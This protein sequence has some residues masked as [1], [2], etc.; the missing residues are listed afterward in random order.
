[1]QIILKYGG[2]IG[3]LAS[4]VHA[5]LY[6]VTMTGQVSSVSD[7]RTSGDDVFDGTAWDVDTYSPSVGDE[8]SYEVIY[9]TDIDPSAFNDQGDSQ[10]AIYDAH[11]ASSISLNGNAISGF[12]SITNFI[13][14]D[15]E[16]FGGLQL[17]GGHFDVYAFFTRQDGL[18]DL[19]N[20]G[21]LPTS[22]AF[23]NGLNL[24][25]LLITN[26]DNFEI[27][28]DTGDPFSVSVEQIPVP[29]TLALAGIGGLMSVRRRR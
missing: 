22:E 15:V 9:D 18:G 27:W 20:G 28:A 21:M 19:I 7:T 29:G 3:V 8:W 6:R 1:M 13:E 4:I 17:G 14:G 16:I 23:F 10:F 11:F 2:A 24:N 12:N 25:S 26:E 5:D